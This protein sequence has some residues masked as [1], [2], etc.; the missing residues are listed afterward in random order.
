MFFET[1][2]RDLLAYKATGGVGHHAAL[3][4]VGTERLVESVSSEQD[5]LRRRSGMP[6][7]KG[8]V[9]VDQLV[10]E[11]DALRQHLDDL[12]LLVVD[13]VKENQLLRDRLF[14][15]LLRWAAEIPTEQEIR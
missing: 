13:L 3:S 10:A 12:R 11:C 9:E 6:E 1:S 5:P 8:Q 15:G 14:R 4:V 2:T 7:L